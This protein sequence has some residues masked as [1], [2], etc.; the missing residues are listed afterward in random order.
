VDVRKLL[1][2]NN[3]HLPDDAC[4]LSISFVKSIFNPHFDTENVILTTRGYDNLEIT[5]IFDDGGHVQAPILHRVYQRY[6][7]YNAVNEV[8]AK[9]GFIII[10]YVN[11]YNY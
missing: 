1:D 2:Q 5:L 10:G 6:A 3:M 8:H 4:F 7:F 11:P 9:S